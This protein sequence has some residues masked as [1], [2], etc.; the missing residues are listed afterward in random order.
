MKKFLF[1]LG[2][3]FLIPVVAHAES[4][5][6]F[7]AN[8]FICGK[9]GTTVT[10]K[11]PI[12]GGTDTVTGTGHDLVYLTINTNQ[13]GQPLRYT[14][15]SDTGC[16]IGYSFNAAGNP[17]KAVAVHRSGVQ[18]I[19]AFEDGKYDPIIN[20]CIHNAPEGNKQATT[21]TAPAAAGSQTASTVAQPVSPNKPA[22]PANKATAAVSK[23][24]T[25]TKAGSTTTATP[26]KKIKKSN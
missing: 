9:E 2:L 3:F 8:G 16:L 15:F 21:T 23:N 1:S 18:K 20:Y 5:P 17:V 6:V 25:S 14:Y 19:F 22:A 10:C 13:E 26:K 24:A 7:S 12:P 4:L 11:G